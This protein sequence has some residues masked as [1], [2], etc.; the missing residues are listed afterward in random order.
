MDESTRH[1]GQFPAGVSGN[2]VG[3]PKG[4][5]NKITLLKQMVEYAA[6]ERNVDM[7]QAVI[8]DIYKDALDGDTVCRK[9]VWAAHMSGNSADDTSAAQEKPQIIIN[10]PVAAEPVLII[11]HP[12]QEEEDNDGT[13]EESA[14]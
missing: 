2:P 8:D 14:D 3:R 11:E 9:L 7:A 13:N 12:S 1:K 6:R 4:S 5:K 10:A